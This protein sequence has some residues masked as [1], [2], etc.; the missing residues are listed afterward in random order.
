MPVEIDI[1]HVDG[2]R[3]DVPSAEPRRRK[4]PTTTPST[5]RTGDSSKP[6][7]QDRSTAPERK[8]DKADG[9]VRSGRRRPTGPPGRTSSG[10]YERRSGSTAPSPVKGGPRPAR[11][12][13]VALPVHPGPGTGH[14]GA[15]PAAAGPA[16]PRRPSTPTVDEVLSVLVRTCHEKPVPSPTTR[17]T[18]TRS[19]AG[20]DGQRLRRR[21]PTGGCG[22]ATEDFLDQ[23]RGPDRR[24]G[25][26]P[27]RLPDR[28][29]PAPLR[30]QPR[31]PLPGRARG[32]DPCSDLDPDLLGEPFPVELIWSYWQEEGGLVQTL[33][34]ILARFQNRRVMHG[35]D[36]LANLN[37]QPAPESGGHPLDLR[38][39][40]DAAAHRAP[41]GPRIPG[42]VRA[43][44]RRPRRAGPGSVVESNTRFVESW[45]TLLHEAHQ[46][47]LTR[48]RHDG[49]CRR[50]PRCTRRCATPISSWRRGPSTV[51][52]SDVPGPRADARDAVGLEPARRSAS[53]SGQADDSV[54]G[55]VAGTRGR[56]EEPH[57][58]DAGQHHAFPR[59][60]GVRR[61]PAA[62]RSAGAPGTAS[63]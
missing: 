42:P 39:G 32:G 6:A 49:Q 44:P 57:R 30:G 58:R 11:D 31:A 63:R 22:S 37:F 46:Y 36:P 43:A 5:T 14:A 52:G 51:P 33:N 60:G 48:R 28:R 62:R 45:H 50:L 27:L 17:R 53:S 4:T 25:R 34:H 20:R 61:A 7:T 54:R 38:R 41:P 16:G 19:S 15:P 40:P 2:Q 1:E 12:P 18:S 56:D 29:A 8:R 10:V 9:T 3:I 47:H 24:P 13:D 21:T 55:G 23:V 35:R 59:D 26:G